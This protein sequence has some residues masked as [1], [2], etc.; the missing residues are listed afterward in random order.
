MTI[1][2]TNGSTALGGSVTISSGVGK[3]TSLGSVA[4]S[5]SNAGT[6]GMLGDLSLNTKTA[7]VGNSGPWALGVACLHPAWALALPSQQAPALTLEV[8][9]G[10]EH[11]E[12][13]RQSFLV[14][15]QLAVVGS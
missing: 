11:L 12:Y 9:S 4:I 15:Q 14:C 2:G 5:K 10:L 13:M 1:I 8:W 3:A 6:M 7:R